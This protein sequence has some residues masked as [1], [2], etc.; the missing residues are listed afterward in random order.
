[1]KSEFSRM[2]DDLFYQMTLS[3]IR[4]ENRKQDELSHNSMLYRKIICK[5]SGKH[6]ISSIAN[7]LSVAT[8]AVTQKVN[9]LEKKGYVTRKQS[10]NDKRISYLYKV[11][12]HCPCG[13]AFTSRDN[14]VLDKLRETHTE[15]EIKV[16]LKV[17]Q[18]MNQHFVEYDNKD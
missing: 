6:T 12:K 16:F 9:E 13:E 17:F 2:M 11:D 3:E 4:I 1:M 10:T 18:E 15:E 8:T 5:E 7:L 14:Y